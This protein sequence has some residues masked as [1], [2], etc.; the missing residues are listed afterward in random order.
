M[1]S[2]V[3]VSILELH[4]CPKIA[5]G[6]RC[7]DELHDNVPQAAESDCTYKCAGSAAEICGGDLRLSLFANENWAPV[8]FVPAQNVGDF[9]YL[10]C[11][12][13]TMN[14]RSLPGLFADDNM[15]PELCAQHCATSKYIGLEFGTPAKWHLVPWFKLADLI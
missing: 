9:S 2:G 6:P 10:G 7:G 13:D 15:T 5:N 14:P 1:G 8:P 4:K 3:L 12:V 11:I